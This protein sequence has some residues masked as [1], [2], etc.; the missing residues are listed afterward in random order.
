[1][2]TA[3]TTVFAATVPANYLAN[4]KATVTVRLASLMVRSLTA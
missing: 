4:L 2:P 1:M 3:R